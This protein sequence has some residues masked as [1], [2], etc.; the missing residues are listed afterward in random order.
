MDTNM[1]HGKWNK[2]QTRK[3][4]ASKKRKKGRIKAEKGNNKHVVTFK[5]G[6]IST[7]Q[8]EKASEV[9]GTKKDVGMPKPTGDR[10]VK[11]P[12]MIDGGLE[13]V[14]TEV[15]RKNES[16][17]APIV[18]KSRAHATG[19]TVRVVDSKDDYVNEVSDMKPVVVY[20]SVLQ[21]ITS[22]S[23]YMCLEDKGN[24]EVI[25]D[26]IIFLNEEIAVRKVFR[27]LL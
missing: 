17:E 23:E 11:E 25:E 22:D 4:K 19:E 10:M 8:G 27:K 9:S 16:N 14:G 1:D 18:L 3:S 13:N 2:E 26:A 7:E 21:G 24:C 5:K 12:K 6:K 20:G 15:E